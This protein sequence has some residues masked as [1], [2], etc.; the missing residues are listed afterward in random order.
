MTI[1]RKNGS[2]VLDSTLTELIVVLFLVCFLYIAQD[3]D[4]IEEGA[5]AKPGF[6]EEYVT[7]G[8]TPVS[9]WFSPLMTPLPPP[10]APPPPLSSVR[11]GHGPPYCF[12]GE[13]E[14]WGVVDLQITDSGVA[15]KERDDTIRFPD[16]LEEK[17][18]LL[19]IREI[20]KMEND[21]KEPWKKYPTCKEFEAF[22]EKLMANVRKHADKFEANCTL[23]A[24]MVFEASDRG[25]A[26]IWYTGCIENYFLPTD[27][28]KY[29][30]YFRKGLSVH[31][32]DSTPLKT[33]SPPAQNKPAP[34][35]ATE[36]LADP[37]Y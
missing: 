20:L 31:E 34:P 11:R 2:N 19:E 16:G 23:H 26:S 29:K 22:G 27:S 21:D 17:R 30:E 25:I 6:F 10:P 4:D 12:Y 15:V 18:P 13:E 33:P 35:P 24:V 8:P 32:P 36:P 14:P 1:L 7:L 37:G 9:S 5:G 3:K 28:E